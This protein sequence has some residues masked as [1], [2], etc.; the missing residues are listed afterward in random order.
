[1]PSHQPF[2][3]E[4]EG[5]DTVIIFIHG[6]LGSPNQFTDYARALAAH[7]LSVASILLPGHGGTG[8][9]FAASRMCDWEG[10][11]RA[12][13]L[14]LAA[15]YARV[16]LVGHSMGGL[17]ALLVSLDPRARVAGVM[18]LSSPQ[19]VR[20]KPSGM[21]NSLESM[22]LPARRQT[23]RMRSYRQGRGITTTRPLT[24]LR[25][26]APTLELFKLM[27]R[28]QSVF[29]QVRCPVWIV[30]S[31]ADETVHWKSGHLLYDGLVHAPR[32]LVFL[33]ESWHAHHPPEEKALLTALIL[34]FVDHA[35]RV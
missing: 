10:Q 25:W 1:M 3:R 21:L 18:T 32:K 13:V 5:S 14:H 33:K 23:P 31:K 22:I 20:L 26:I 15:R 8:E 6:F 12:Q 2:V 9:A 11:V 27:R 7:G 24:Y 16:L 17:L 28:T 35:P 19:R 30:Q 29:S 34:E 4:V